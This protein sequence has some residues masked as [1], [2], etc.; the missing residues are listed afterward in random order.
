MFE[1]RTQEQI[2]KEVLAE[3]DPATGLS[4]MAGSFADAVVGPV[5]REI[6]ELYKAL[7][8]VVSMLF[9]DENSGGFLD[10]VGKSYF[11]ITRR[12]GT[13]ARCRITLNGD[14]GTK[15][16][17]ST[18]FL[19]A[20]GLEFVLMEA[21]S[22]PEGGT[23]QGTLEAAQD[24]AAY[25]IGAG[26][27]VSMYVNVPGL[28]SYTNEEA[29]G[30]TDTESDGALYQRIRERRQKPINGANGWQYRS[31][32][33]EVAGVGDAKV[34]EVSGGPGTVGV[35]VVDS[36]YSPAAPEIVEAVQAA[37]DARRP[38]G[39]TV[40]VKA[41]T[42]LELSVNTVVVISSATTVQTVK[43]ELERRLKEY[44]ASLVAE[45]YGTVYYGPEEDRV[46]TVIYNR[47]LALLLTI[48]G[49]ENAT[50]LTVNGGTTDVTVQPAEVPTA[51]TVEVTS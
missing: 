13:R 14:A 38:I 49:V 47:I 19:T 16:P 32:A 22:I 40:T 10:L 4:S 41:P 42:E 37:L 7:P 46:Y 23:A 51:G 12:P 6:S 15:I 30:G 26:A 50:S 24:G 39:A 18:S 25:N 33:L 36:T 8:A 34:V 28:A 1:N 43:A 31:W 45:K 3:I 29:A 11:D 20:T 48:D 2:K 27:I 35:T 21:V 5:A 44:L 9:V 17:A